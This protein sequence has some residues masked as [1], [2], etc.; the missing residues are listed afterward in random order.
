MLLY[1][2][3]EVFDAQRDCTDHLD[4]LQDEVVPETGLV[5]LANAASDPRA[6][7]VVSGDTVIAGLAVLG[8][9]GLFQV[10]DGAIL[11]FDE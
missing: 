9:K 2:L 4:K 11:H 5:P 6:M 7:M 8:T 10:T 3:N 1:V